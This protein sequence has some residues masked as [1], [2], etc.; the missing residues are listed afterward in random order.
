MTPHRLPASCRRRYACAAL[1]ESIAMLVA[2]CIAI[3]TLTVAAVVNGV[4][5]TSLGGG[6][7]NGM[8]HGPTRRGLLA[9]RS[10]L[11]RWATESHRR[12]P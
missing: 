12:D 1:T 6:G 3:A 2:E 8:I 4:D 10:T 9:R 5:G 11:G 7:A